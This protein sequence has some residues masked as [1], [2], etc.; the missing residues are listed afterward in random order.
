VRDGKADAFSIYYGA[1]GNSGQT[2]R[3]K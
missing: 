1:I 2:K 3:K